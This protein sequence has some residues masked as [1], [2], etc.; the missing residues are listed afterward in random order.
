[1][2]RIKQSEAQA[3]KA[4]ERLASVAAAEARAAK[5]EA[6]L[7]AFAADLDDRKARL[8]R[9]HEDHQVELL[10]QYSL[11]VVWLNL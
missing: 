6:S 7:L 9:L 4:S 8:D 2:A 11:L 3:A 5:K 1:M 10:L